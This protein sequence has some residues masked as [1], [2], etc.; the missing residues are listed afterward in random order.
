MSFSN[1][2]QSNA[3]QHNAFQIVSQ[4]SDNKGGGGYIGGTWSR[5]KWH[6][7]VGQIARE[8][9]DIV[10]RKRRE[11]E[12]IEAKRAAAERQ[13]HVDFLARLNQ[14]EA[15]NARILRSLALEHAQQ[16]AAQTAM[17]QRMALQHE[18]QQAFIR[19]MMDDED[20]EALA[21]LENDD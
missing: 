2:F 17:A 1:A 6:T 19:Q 9:E 18:Q 7:L 15:D 3:F 10:R 8:R 12:E 11:L 4:Q 21:L 16:T 5:G 14:A 20:E 13:A